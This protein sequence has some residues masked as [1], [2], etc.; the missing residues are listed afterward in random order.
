MN[1]DPKE[2]VQPG[3]ASLADAK[4][5][6]KTLVPP[7][8]E[9]QRLDFLAKLRES[10]R[11]RQLA[12]RLLAILA[13][14]R[15]GRL[16]R[17][18]SLFEAE[19]VT[20]LSGGRPPMPAVG[21]MPQREVVAAWVRSQF[22]A[23][24]TPAEAALHL[25]GEQH[26]WPLY[27]ILRSWADTP[28]FVAALTL[29]ADELQLLATA[30]SRAKQSRQGK[31]PAG[32][33][34]VVSSLVKRVPTRPAALAP[35]LEVLRLCRVWAAASEELQQDL[36]DTRDYSLK[37]K[38]ELETERAES[39]AERAAREAAEARERGALASLA[40]AQATIDSLQE[41]LRIQ[42]GAHG[43]ESKGAV[44]DAIAEL[45]QKFLPELENIR[46]YADRAEPNT[47][48]ILRKAQELTKFMTDFRNP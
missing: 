12:F 44:A 47:A 46:L 24:A 26:L 39:A 15:S 19:L 35:L 25:E 43:A 31:R 40:E 11:Q 4:K 33:S 8:S 21:E 28:R 10:S 18:L 48:A 22:A 7:V 30:A 2:T 45:R 13:A 36:A 6:L 9:G 34:S 38:A 3:F 23:A 14:S 32:F 29:Y 37:L 1:P 5:A 16:Q 27:Q 41:T 42:A 17:L 20:V